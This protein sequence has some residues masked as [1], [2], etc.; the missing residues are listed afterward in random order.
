MSEFD[1]YLE[2]LRERAGIALS[3]EAER[4]LRAHFQEAVAAH[5]AQGRSRSDAE[6]EALSELG[7]PEVVAAAFRRE[8]RAIWRLAG[9]PGA[10]ALDLAR[11]W[12]TL[13]VG[14]LLAGAL[15]ALAGRTVL[16]PTYEARIPLTVA[17]TMDFGSQLGASQLLDALAAGLPLRPHGARPAIDVQDHDATAA[18]RRAEVAAQ[19]VTDEF[20]ARFRLSRYGGDAV[21]AVVRAMPPSVVARHPIAPATAG[22]LGL[23]LVAG[24]ALALRR[25]RR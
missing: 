25:R 9:S 24:G 23:G 21:T 3:P 11:S 18:V 17:V 2:R 22:G 1:R 19:V 5:Q 20:P 16:P 15:G 4:E 6:V 13:L 14:S 7:R 8:R 12:R 10:L